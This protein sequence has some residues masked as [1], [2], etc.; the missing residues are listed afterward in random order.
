MSVKFVKEHTLKMYDKNT[1]RI[2]A[3]SK[4]DRECEGGRNIS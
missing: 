3:G 4:S 1:L 2:T